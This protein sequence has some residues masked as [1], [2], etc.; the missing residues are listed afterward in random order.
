MSIIKILVAARNWARRHFFIID[1]KI[2]DDMKLTHV[3]NM[4]SLTNKRGEVLSIWV[5]SKN[6]HYGA[7]FQL[8]RPLN[9]DT[10]KPNRPNNPKNKEV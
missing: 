3:M 8:T 5:D 2:V 4:P 7:D 1:E 9:K 10:L 6:R